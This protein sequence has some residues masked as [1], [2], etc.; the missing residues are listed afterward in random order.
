MDLC[1]SWCVDFPNATHLDV[2]DCFFLDQASIV[3]KV[4]DFRSLGDNRFPPGSLPGSEKILGGG[5]GLSVVRSLQSV[6]LAVG[7]CR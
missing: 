2:M 3:Q 5:G 6:V 7:H 1:V 4:W